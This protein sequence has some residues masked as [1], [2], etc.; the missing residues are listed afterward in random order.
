MGSTSVSQFEAVIEDTE[1]DSSCQKA[2][3]ANIYNG[4]AVTGFEPASVS[5]GIQR[6][7]PLVHNALQFT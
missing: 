5:F 1:G 2:A 6:P 7:R 3:H 4:L